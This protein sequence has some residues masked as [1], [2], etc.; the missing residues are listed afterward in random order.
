MTPVAKSRM[1]S[2]EPSLE[3]EKSI[4]FREFSQGQNSD[5][6]SEL[7]YGNLSNHK[8]ILDDE[9]RKAPVKIANFRDQFRAPPKRGNRSHYR[10][11]DDGYTNPDNPE[12]TTQTNSKYE[13]KLGFLE[14]CPQNGDEES[15][16]AK[17]PP[18]IF[19]TPPQKPKKQMRQF[20][21]YAFGTNSKAVNVPDSGVRKYLMAPRKH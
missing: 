3:D 20:H 18:E 8:G 7:S 11:S 21:H 16:E 19:S 6:D 15:E 1:S 12:L 4:R 17:I 13:P 5:S 2:R 14:F 9:L 10:D